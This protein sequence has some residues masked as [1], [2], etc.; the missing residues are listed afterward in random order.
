MINYG[1]TKELNVP[2]GTVIELARD[3]LKKEGF[4]ILTQIDVREKMKE[5]LGID[6]SEYII[7]GACILRTPIKRSLQRKTS[8]SCSP[9][10]LLFMKK[11]ARLFYP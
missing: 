11:A 2:Y 5:K 3:A 6:M 8:G 4:G 1:F 9:V 7:L 10:T